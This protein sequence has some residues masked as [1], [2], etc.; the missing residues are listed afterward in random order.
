MSG[1][2]A[3][4]VLFRTGPRGVEVLFIRRAQR[5]GDP[6][7][8][9]I[10]LPGGRRD[11]EDLDLQATALRET[12]EEVGL[13]ATVLEGPPVFAGVRAPAN[14]PSLHV[15]VFLAVLQDGSRAEAHSSPEADEVFWAP[16]HELCASDREVE[17]STPRGPWRAEGFHFQGHVVWGLTRRIL[18]D[19]LARYGSELS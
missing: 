17:V 2:A 18:L 10:S 19:V 8:G 7:S 6:W 9:Q 3:V 13:D 14:R 5:E 4:L 12:E 15:G 16:L 1:E 11:P